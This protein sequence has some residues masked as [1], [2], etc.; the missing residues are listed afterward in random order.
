[1][2][3]FE[4]LLQDS[5]G[6]LWVEDLNLPGDTLRTWTVFDRDGVPLTRLS[7]PRANRV[8]DIGRDYVLTT[9]EDE[10]GVEYVREYRLT[11]GD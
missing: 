5:E 8:H 9:F 2:P 11:R 6:F 4:A 10:L 7:L 3:A 1:M